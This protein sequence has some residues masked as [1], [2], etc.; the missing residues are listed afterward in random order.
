MRRAGLR[1][2]STLLLAAALILVAAGVARI[3]F[4]ALGGPAGPAAP[5]PPATR[6]VRPAA[7]EP[8]AGPA[9]PSPVAA[10]PHQEEPDV[11]TAAAL[12]RL[13]SELG[14]YRS[15]L[16]E[17]ERLIATREAVL[18][19]L[20]TRI[21]EQVRRL[22]QASD[23]LKRGIGEVTIEERA[24]IAQLVKVYEAMKAQSAAVIFDPM[25]LELLLPIVRGMR[26]TKVAAIVAEMDPA[27]ARA[28]TVELARAAGSP[29]KP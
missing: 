6:E 9:Q 29:A 23:E 1:G 12:E 5:L 19:T 25:P 15:T 22:E 16:Q 14:G 11:P 17:R 10:S 8:E 20:E 27:K 2:L 3:A 13:A 26:E 21:G 18:A 4:S 24:R 28:L 7:I